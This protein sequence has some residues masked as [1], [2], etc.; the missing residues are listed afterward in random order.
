MKFFHCEI[1]RFKEIT[2]QLCAICP[3][4]DRC[5]AFRLYF[6]EN[7]V[8][9]INF[10]TRIVEKFPDKYQLEVLFMAEKQ[11]F[12]QIVDQETGMVERIADLK[13]IEALSVEDK[14]ALARNKTLYVVSHKLEPVIKVEM[15]KVSLAPVTYKQET[16][17]ETKTQVAAQTKT[18]P[19]TKKEEKP[20]KKTEI[21][22]STP[23]KGKPKKTR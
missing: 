9:Y 20:V 16:A 3:R 19:V 10:V 13:E 23:G 1:K 4:I 11:T 21:P 12:V 6:R 15:K 18:Q 22:L 2:P 14:L 5:R 7:S 8:E 17:E